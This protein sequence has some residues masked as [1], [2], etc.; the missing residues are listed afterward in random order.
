MIYSLVYIIS[1]YNIDNFF[2]YVYLPLFDT[3]TTLMK[4]EP[5]LY[6]LLTMT[7]YFMLFVYAY[8]IIYR[9]LIINNYNIYSFRLMAIYLKYIVDILLIPNTTMVEYEMSRTIMWVFATPVMLDMLSEVNDI[10]CLNIHYHILCVILSVFVIPLKNTSIYW[11]FSFLSIVFFFLFLKKLVAFYHLPFTN[12][13]IMIWII[14]F[15][16]FSLEILTPVPTKYIHAFFNIS[17]TLCK[18]ICNTVI[19]NHIEEQIIMANYMDL[20]STE[21]VTKMIRHI[22]DYKKN[23]IQ[24][25][26]VC[27]YFIKQ[28]MKSFS[29]KIPRT[30]DKLKL[31]LL[32]K[33]L[34]FNLADSYVDFYNQGMN[35]EFTFICVLF[36]DIVNYTEL[37]KKYDGN[38]IFRLL[39]SVY[40]HFDNIIKK[41]QHLQKIETIGDAYMVVG[42]IYRHKLNHKIVVKEIILLGLEFIR[43]IKTIETPDKIPLSIRVGISIG[44]VNIGVLGNEIPRL[45]IVGNTVNMASRL[46]ST[47]DPNTIQLS[48]HIHEFIDEIDFGMD[49]HI[50]EK[51]MVFLKNVGTV[52]TFVITPTH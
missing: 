4:D 42:D 25:T 43:E 2:R 38:T 33:I 19:F 28:F 15:C 13:F 48:R 34:P 5:E 49:L 35:T 37:A 36:M 24:I 17:D 9:F 39:H 6:F 16:I 21:F 26:D 50:Q 1:Y 44:P 46:Q 32:K 22:E 3:P 47:A 23:H 51:T 31:E 40:N 8:I 14:F 20:Q 11:A 27:D 45:C 18:F 41:Y 52:S 12:T 30:N 7:S 29:E 10:K